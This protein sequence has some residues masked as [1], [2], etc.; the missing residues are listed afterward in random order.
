MKRKICMLRYEKCASVWKMCIFTKK[1]DVEVLENGVKHS[2]F[3]TC[4]LVLPCFH[5]HKLIGFCT[6]AGVANVSSCWQNCKPRPKVVSYFCLLNK[7][8]AATCRAFVLLGIC[9]SIREYL[10]AV[11]CLNNN[12]DKLPYIHTCTHAHIHTYIHIF[13]HIYTRNHK[14]ICMRMDIY[15]HTCTCTSVCICTPAPIYIHLPSTHLYIHVLAGYLCLA[16]RT[17]PISCAVLP[18]VCWALGSDP[19]LV[20]PSRTP[21]IYTYT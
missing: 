13:I 2:F 14:H 4:G 19:E 1:C 11:F 15:T 16:V 8:D 6:H 9:I 20:H 3:S 12:D 5:M 17:E 18:T 10:Y 7:I 21:C